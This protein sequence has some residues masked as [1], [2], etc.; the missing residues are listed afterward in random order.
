MKIYTFPKG[1]NKF[2]KDETI[3]NCIVNKELYNKI[4]DKNLK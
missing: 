3:S 1:I 2:T 4:Q